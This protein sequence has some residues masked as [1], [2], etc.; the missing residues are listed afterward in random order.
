MTKMTKKDFYEV[1][2]NAMA[3]NA[4]VVEFCEKEIAALDRKAEKAKERA[5][6]KRAEGDTLVEVV[7]DALNAEEFEPMATIVERV[8]TVEGFEEI[9]G[10][11]L[12][13]R[14]TALINEGR[15]EKAKISVVGED[16]KAKKVTGYR[17]L[18][19]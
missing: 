11:K 1:I 13:S 3:D 2:K 18:T 17:A 12:V 14:M 6:A 7:A 19:V 5:A 10:A 4:E 9:T 15:A 8:N 16:G